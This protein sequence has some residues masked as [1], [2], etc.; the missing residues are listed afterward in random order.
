MTEEKPSS[1]TRRGLLKTLAALGALSVTGTGAAAAVKTPP[2]RLLRVA[3]IL[4]RASRY[5][6]MAAQFQRGLQAALQGQPVQL[7]TYSTGPLPRE[8]QVATRAALE[9]G[10]DLLI[11]LGDGLSSTVQTALDGQAVPIIA[12]EIGASMPGLHLRPAPLTVTLSLHAWEAEWAHGA[13]LARANTRPLHLLISQLEAGYDL[14]YA[15]SS[16]Y[17]AAGGRLTGTTLFDD[18]R[19]DV[20]ALVDQVR[21]HGAKAVH[22]IASGTGAPVAAACQRAG[23]DVT[24]GGLT[25]PGHAFPSA[26]AAASQLSAQTQSAVTSRDPLAVL[27]YDAG[28]WLSAAL[29]A[30]PSGAAPAPLGL[31]AALLHTPLTGA[32]GLLQADGHGQLRAPLLLRRAGK[33][34]LALAAPAQARPE[35]HRPDGLRSG[36]LYTYL[37]A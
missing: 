37:H 3:V 31:Q 8:A 26:L 29:A 6:D 7:A 17:A 32:R 18:Q 22:V 23:L 33:P 34:D 27:G 14:P 19:P 10:A 20:A 1:P 9:A 15:F 36:W 11:L 24:V 5:P 25:A 4:P 28:R 21:R 2:G 13:H 16:G 35:F 12:A 30:L